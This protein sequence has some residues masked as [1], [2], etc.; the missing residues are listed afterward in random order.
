MSSKKSN[1]ML[2]IWYVHC[3]RPYNEDFMKT[4][5]KQKD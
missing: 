3:S 2:Y 1:L 5:Y 4:K